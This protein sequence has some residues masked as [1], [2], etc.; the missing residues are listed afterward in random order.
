MAQQSVTFRQWEVLRHLNAD[1]E[2]PQSDLAEKMGLEAQT[3]AGILSRME[4]DGLLVRKY[5]S[6]DR[7]RK[8]ISP[9][10]KAERIWHDM[11]ACCER[12]KDRAI[13]NLSEAELSQLESTCEKIRDNLARDCTEFGH[14]PRDLYH[15][16]QQQTEEEHRSESLEDTRVDFDET[17]APTRTP[18]P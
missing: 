5:C 16:R 18:R 6:E 10:R 1:G 12:V 14:L 3:L 17:L 13:L 4:R 2:Q 8:L 9:S 11:Q 7:R 15:N